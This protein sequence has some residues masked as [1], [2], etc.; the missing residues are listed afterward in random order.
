[1]KKT[2]KIIFSFL[3]CFIVSIMTFYG[4]AQPLL[5]APT[6]TAEMVTTGDALAYEEYIYFANAFKSFSSLTKNDNDIGNVINE[7][8][9]RVK[10]VDNKIEYD[11]ETNMPENVELVLSKVLGSDHTFLFSINDY[12]YFASPNSRK[13]MSSADKFELTT[14]FRVKT[15]G[16]NLSEIYTTETEVSNQTILKVENKNYLIFQDGTSVV[17]IEL[18]N[19]IGRAETIATE[20]KNVVFAKTVAEENDKYIYYTTDISDELINLG[21]TGTYIYKLDITTGISTLMN[22][23]G[24]SNKTIT[25]VSVVNGNLHFTMNDSDSLTY[26]YSYSSGAFST[27]VKI[28][29]PID[30]ITVN[31]FLSLKSNSND[32]TYYIF[33][34]ST[35]NVNKTYCLQSGSKDFSE[36]NLLVGSAIEILFAYNDYVYYAVENEGIYRIS[37][38]DKVVQTVALCESFKTTNIGF[39]GKYV[40]FYKTSEV[41]STGTYYMHRADV[42][43]AERGNDGIIELVGF[44]D[45]QD[46]PE[47]TEE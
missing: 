38:L 42:R 39:D 29:N 37:V 27:A 43:N 1:M 7:A 33:S 10:L 2:I 45:E 30:N 44:L 16:T 11:E 35:D 21:Q 41:N 47:E 25:P 3:A 34:V 17:K 8:L 46:M 4:C 18:G 13:D 26:Y 24:Y 6:V 14:Y 28:S 5:T 36:S 19:S 32:R 20:I 31:N 12:I 22:E 9:Y 40:Y 23:T 15:D